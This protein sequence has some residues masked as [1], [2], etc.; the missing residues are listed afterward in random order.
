MASV[1]AEEIGSSD[2]GASPPGGL[3]VQGV[4]VVAGIGLILSCAGLGPD[5]E[6]SSRIAAAPSSTEGE[7]ESSDASALERRFA[8]LAPAGGVAEADLATAACATACADYS[9]NYG[10]IGYA[11]GAT[12]ASMSTTASIDDGGHA[13]SIPVGVSDSSA[14]AVG[15]PPATAAQQTSAN[16]AA[17]G[18]AP[19][20]GLEARRAAT[21]EALAPVVVAMNSQPEL[22]PTMSRPAAAEAAPSSLQPKVDWSAPP[23][24]VD[25]AAIN[26]AVRREVAMS[27][28]LDTLET[29]YVRPA[30]SPNWIAPYVLPRGAGP[31]FPGA[32]PPAAPP[33]SR[34]TPDVG[35]LLADAR[36]GT[37]PTNAG[38]SPVDILFNPQGGPLEQ[39]TA[40]QP[41]TRYLPFQQ[42]NEPAFSAPSALIAA[43]LPEPSTLALLGVALWGWAASSGSGRRKTDYRPATPR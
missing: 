4:R 34:G 6:R 31:N 26:P 15:A 8:S 10:N 43:V 21:P 37:S 12:I 20:R 1:H 28:G 17:P 3:L 13:P 42:G 18:A 39:T 19:Y 9:K 14:G 38:E 5:S 33:I 23:A 24:S 40:E 32:L 7:A 16:L 41:P 22:A 30:G 27:R 36:D 2:R 11:D 29:P 25:V 35:D